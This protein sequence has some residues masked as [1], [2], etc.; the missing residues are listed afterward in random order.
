M[1]SI[2]TSDEIRAAV[3]EQWRRLLAEEERGK[4]TDPSDFIA[5]GINVA[6]AFESHSEEIEQD[7]RESIAAS[8]GPQ[9]V[10]TRE[11]KA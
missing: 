1:T 8:E 7:I 2:V 4:L 9:I 3:R 10:V 11:P 5:L 6:R